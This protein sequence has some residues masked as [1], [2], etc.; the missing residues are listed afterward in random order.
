MTPAADIR[1]R[2]RWLSCYA[3]PAAPLRLVCLPHAGAG[4]SLFRDWPAG[5]DGVAEVC[6]VQLPG[7]E[8]RL[9]E[10][11]FDD[12]SELVEGLY[13][14]LVRWLDRPF[15]LLGMSM[16]ALVAYELAHRLRDAGA[17]EPRLLLV[18]AHRAPHL[19]DRRAPVADLPDED[20]LEEVRR[21]DGTPAEVLEHSE[22]RELLLGTVRADLALCER[23]TYLD[24]PPLDVALV[25]LGGRDD[26]EVTPDELAAWGDETT[27]PFWATLLEGG[28]FLAA[29]ARPTFLHE[30]RHRL[31]DAALHAD[32][33]HADGRDA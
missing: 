5:L 9:A 18:I 25:A 2:A 22:L 14:G 26:P 32:R 31:R 21:L 12:M 29:D 11:P 4:A 24:R 13:A 8:S 27:G 7:R 20:V 19:P 28:H 30:I 6:P 17:P 16:G 23:Y 10:P 3:T 33:W 1:G 15:A